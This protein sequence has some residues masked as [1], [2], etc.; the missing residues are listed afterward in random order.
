MHPRPQPDTPLGKLWVAVSA[1]SPIA[2]LLP[3]PSPLRT[4]IADNLTKARKHQFGL[5]FNSQ[6]ATAN[7][8]DVHWKLLFGATPTSCVLQWHHGQA[9]TPDGYPH[10]GQRDTY[11][12]FYLE[13]VHSREYWGLVL[14]LLRVIL[15]QANEFQPGTGDSAQIM[16][17][18]PR[19][20]FK[21]HSQASR[22]SSTLRSCQLSKGSRHLHLHFGF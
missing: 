2:P 20:K 19:V 22:E 11:T 17:G 8:K 14:Q 5:W 3:R 18:L 15:D 12:H 9:T 6:W 7:E 4:I 13:C 10:C 16:L 21:V 1:C